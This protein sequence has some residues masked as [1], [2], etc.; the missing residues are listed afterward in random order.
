MQVK[1]INDDS[2]QVKLTMNTD[3]DGFKDL[4]A[5]IKKDGLATGDDISLKLKDGKFFIST[6]KNKQKKHVKNTKYFSTA[7]NF[8]PL[9]YRRRK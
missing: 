9:P 4:V 3:A 2:A 6:I 1:V 7:K 8:K 5:A